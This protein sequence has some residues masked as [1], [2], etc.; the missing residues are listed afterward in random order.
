MR[1]ATTAG[2]GLPGRQVIEGRLSPSLRDG[3]PFHPGEPAAERESTLS[4]PQ[5]PFA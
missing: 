5:T 1:A 4:I 3:M 2:D